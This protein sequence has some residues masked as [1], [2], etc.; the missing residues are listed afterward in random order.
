MYRK[1][2][3]ALECEPADR[4][5][6]DHVTML[7]RQMHSELLLLHV[8]DGYAARHFHQLALAESDEMKADRAYL[9]AAA[10]R[11]RACGLTVHTQLAL[12]EPS[13]EILKVA[14]AGRF[15]LIAMGSHGHRFFGDLF[16]GS[17]IREVRHKTT[18]PVLLVRGEKS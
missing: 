1:I 18:I 5:L 3:V 4:N 7:A 17:T 16:H 10:T 8:A 12:G 13:K 11:L 9:E 2:L 14:A 6:L 15:D